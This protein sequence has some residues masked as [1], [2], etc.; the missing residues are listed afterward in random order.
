M[1]HQIYYHIVWTTR[2]RRAL[3][4]AEVAAFLDRYFRAI[5]GRERC[6]LL[7]LGMASTHIHLL[8]RGH[9]MTV[10]PRLMQRLKGGSSVIA[11]QE[12][13]LPRNHAL[14]WA[15]GYSIRSISPRQ[16]DAVREYV[17]S[18][19]VRHPDEAIP[20][21]RGGDRAWDEVVA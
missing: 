15:E 10:I 9:P 20:G 13:G 8:L 2:E 4:T 17:R 6:H 11:S 18:Q 5:A 16:V 12:M 21:W 19:A 1:R 7:E 3:I 14:R